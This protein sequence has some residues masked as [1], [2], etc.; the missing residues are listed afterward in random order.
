MVKCLVALAEE[1][2]AAPPSINFIA[3]DG[4]SIAAVRLGRGLF[5]STQKRYCEKMNECSRW[6]EGEELPCM[7]PLRAQEVNHLLISSETISAEDIWEPLEEGEMIGI[8]ADFGFV[9]QPALEM[10]IEVLKTRYE[11]FYKEDGQ[12][13][14]HAR[15]MGLSRF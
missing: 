10:D 4:R 7:H 11:P 2:H 14:R 6:R 5:F 8:D 12:D 3:T 1:A 9:R 15:A 13:A